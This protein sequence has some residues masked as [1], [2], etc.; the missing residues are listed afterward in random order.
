MCRVASALW[1][2]VAHM[3]EWAAR[4]INRELMIQAAWDELERLRD[5][6]SDVA[7]CGQQ[8]A[9]MTPQDADD[10]PSI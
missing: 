2:D 7:G 5:N 8:E 1:R 4:V 9:T 6:I 3:D 10:T